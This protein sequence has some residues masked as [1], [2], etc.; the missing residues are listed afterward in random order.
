MIIKVKVKPHSGKQD[1]VKKG[2]DY[3][4][5]LK[6]QPEDGKANIELIKLLKKHFN[7]QVKIKCAKI[8]FLLNKKKTKRGARACS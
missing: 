8:T 6:S 3:M 1:V 5:Y 7:K 2:D 4:V